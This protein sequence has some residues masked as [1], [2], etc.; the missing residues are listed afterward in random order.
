MLRI[1]IVDPVDTT[2]DPLR[3]LMLGVD[4][5][6][7]E[8]ESN[9]YEFFP[10]VIRESPPDLL[11]VSLDA[12]KAKA[13]AL[14]VHLV[15][16]FPQTP[17]LVISEDNQAILQSLQR[18]ARHFLTRPVV[19]EDLLVCLR[20]VKE[21]TPTAAEAADPNY[22]VS[23]SRPCKVIAVLGSR[24][25]VGCTTL[26]VNLACNLAADPGHTVALVDLD[27]ALGDA[28]VALD[29]MP[30]HTLA[31]LAMNIEKLDLNYMKRSLLRH[32]PTNLNVLA[33]PLQMADVTVIQPAHVER[34]LKLLRINHT[35][36]VLDLSKGL[37]PTD[38]VGLDLADIILLV[39]QLE[40]SSL[41]NVVRLVM[42]LGV[43]E[44]VG[45]KVRV[46]VNRVGAD[47]TEGEIGLKRA[48]ATIGRPVFWQVPNDAKGV[49]AARA[50]GEPLCIHAPKCRAQQSLVALAAALSDRPAVMTEEQTGGIFKSIFGGRK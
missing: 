34:V 8:A 30:D 35:H 31:D 4:F 1:A 45:E 3:S 12:D 49:L 21:S 18:G 14:I 24:G 6:F 47:Y 19:L 27:L 25:G 13:L 5:V 23:G 42:T 50:T 16:E 11:I 17:V 44:G 43:Q 48:E 20:K 28:D 39:A 41:R 37:T 22:T 46:V 10:D 7:L 29:L 38:L 32:E 36:L 2:R 33:H 15:H 26:A 40:L 9:R